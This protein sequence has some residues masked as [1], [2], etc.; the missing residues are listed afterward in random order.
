M[1]FTTQ[2]S[3]LLKALQSLQAQAAGRDRLAH[4]SDVLLRTVGDNQIEL[5]AAEVLGHT[6]IATV[7]TISRAG[8]VYLP[9]KRFS[10]ILRQA[11]GETADFTTTP[12]GEVRMECGER[13]YHLNGTAL[14]AL[15]PIHV[16]EYIASSKRRRKVR[17]SLLIS[18]FL[19]LVFVIIFA[20]TIK[21]QLVN[22]EPPIMVAW[23]EPPPTMRTPKKPIVER[24][25]PKVA[26]NRSL[27]PIEQTQIHISTPT[28]VAETARQSLTS[29]QHKIEFSAQAP[30]NITA[31]VT[32]AARI[33]V[34][35]HD[36]V[37]SPS[38]A[39]SRSGAG[40]EGLFTGRS[41]TPGL[42]NTR[43]DTQSSTFKSMV[44]STGAVDSAD[45]SGA[46]FTNLIMVPENKLGAVLI[47]QGKDIQG[48]IRLIRLKHSL[49]DWWQ[50]P[51]ALPSFMKWLSEH[52]RLQ[53]DMK[54]EGGALPLTDPRIFD[55]PLIIMT[56]HDKDITVGRNL[57]KDGPLIDSLSS[58]ERVALRKYI[59][60]RGG[61][62]FFDDCGFNGLFAEQVASEL[63]QIFPEYP[64]ENIEHNHEIY[65]MYYQLSGPP[66]GGDVFWGSENNPKASK[67]KYQKGITIG[68]R[69]AVVYNRKD[70]M[71]AMETA[72]IESRTMLRMRRSPDV[73]RFMTNLLFYTMKYG[74]NTERSGYK[75]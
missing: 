13:T 16:A 58:A 19:H 21:N 42:E 67:F 44:E 72:E 25:Q 22:E 27:K 31:P 49:S 65:T 18:A 71:C 3:D 53:A 66:T 4:L 63:R 56:G 30:E 50:D 37:V 75:N 9:I 29:I 28:P 35:P 33:P 64:L 70:Y 14:E 7:A 48:H 43:G 61:T 60:E 52:T 2:K 8:A 24:V 39:S 69:L 15:A 26:L 32:T 10:E 23:V 17:N 11:Q 54:F 57:V 46:R 41:G 73:H 45:L 47:G 36:L 34:G 55:A 51:T 20:L 1:Q 12:D 62:L 74:G 68:R 5:S 6:Q 59:I 40:G 38:T